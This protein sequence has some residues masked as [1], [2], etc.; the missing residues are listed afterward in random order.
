MPAPGGQRSGPPGAQRRGPAGGGQRGGP[1]GGSRGGPRKRDDDSKFNAAWVPKTKLG[2]LVYSG[3]ITTMS[4]ALDTRLP[5]KEPEIVDIL[6]PELMDEVLDV[7]MVQR[8]TDSG[9]RVRFAITAVV[10]NGDGFVGMGR[11]KGKEVGPAIRNAIDRAK[12]NMI[13]VKRGCGS[14]ECGCGTPHTVPFQVEGKCGSVIVTL[15]PAPRG[16][17]LALGDIAKKIVTMAGIKD[18]WSTTN[19]HTKTTVNYSFAA[20]E[21]LRQTARMRVNSVQAKNLHILTGPVNKVYLDTS[22]EERAR[23]AEEKKRGREQEL[24]DKDVSEEDVAG[25]RPKQ[26]KKVLESAAAKPVEDIS[27][28]DEEP[29][30]EGDE[31]KSAE[32]DAK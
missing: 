6:L 13:E 12:L 29:V 21:A 10:G 18:S 32:G 11:A 23:I 20:F 19:G 16:V 24:R 7:N 9:R 15:K 22:P 25:K 17:G 1:R 4:E 30:P 28:I 14:W 8:M 31:K 2:K 27:K 3:K 5:L 26:I